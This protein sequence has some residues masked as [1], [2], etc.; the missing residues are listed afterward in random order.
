M[1]TLAELRGKIPELEGLDDNAAVDAIQQAYYPDIDRKQIA[2]RLGVQPVAAPKDQNQGDLGRGFKTAFEQLPQLGYGV[3]A[4]V[5][6]A[7][8]A[9]LGSGGVMSGIKEA[10]LKGYQDWGDK[11]NAGSKESDSWSYSYDQ[12]KAGNFGALVD[13]LQYGLGYSAGQGL[14]ALA[15]AGIGAVGGKVVL[16]T[17]AKEL[18]KGLVLK[19]AGVI[20]AT[21]AGKALGKD[22][23]ISMATQNVASKIGQSVGVGAMAFG[24]EGGEI[25]G[26]LTQQAQ[27]D[28]RDLTGAELGKAFA[29]TL[30]AGG[31]EFVGDKFGLDLVMGKSNVGSKLMGLAE[32]KAG[33]GGKVAR[34]ALAGAAAI[35]AEAGTEYLQTGL[36]EYGKGNEAN[37]LPMFQSEQN[38]AGALDAAMLGG[39]GG[40]SVGVAGGMMSRAR[41]KVEA[42]RRLDSAD[43]VPDMIGAATDLALA[44]IQAPVR[45]RAAGADTIAEIR[46]LDPE[47]QSEAIGL[48]GASKN[49]NAPGHV[50]RYAQNRL[51]ELLAPFRMVPV[52]EATE[53][54]VEQVNGDRMAYRSPAQILADGL[55]EIEAE[56]MARSTA[57]AQP[58]PTES[59]AAAGAPRPEGM[60]ERTGSRDGQLIDTSGQNAVAAY[61]NRM[62]QINTPA[63]RAFVQDVDAGRITPDDV[64]S[65]MLPKRATSA[66]QEANDRLAAAA[67]QAPTIQPGDLLTADGMPYGTRAAAAVRSTREGGGSVVQVPGGFV[68]R[69]EGAN[70]DQ[71]DVAAASAHAAGGGDGG[72]AVPGGSG[73]DVRRVPD[74]R[75]GVGVDAITA[76]PGGGGGSAVAVGGGSQPDAALSAEKTPEA[77]WNDKTLEQR[78]GALQAVGYT[79]A[80][81]IQQIANSRWHE[82]A[83]GVRAKVDALPADDAKSLADR[84]NAMKAA[85]VSATADQ[86]T[87]KGGPESAQ[88]E[89]AQNIDAAAHEAA[90]SPV[91]DLPQPTEAQKKAGNYAKGHAVINGLD[92]SIEN[93]AGSTRSGTDRGG[94]AWTNTLQHH[95]G[96]IKGTIGNDKDHVDAFVKPGTPQDYAGPVFVVDQIHPETGKFDEHKALIGFAS[97]AEA[98]SAYAANYAKDWKGLK[99]ITEM[100]FEQFKTWVKD[101]AKRMPASLKA[102]VDAKRS[103]SALAEAPASEG[104][105]AATSAT[106]RDWK[107]ATPAELEAEIHRLDGEWRDLNTRQRAEPER[108]GEQRAR[109][110]SQMDDVDRRRRELTNLLPDDQLDEADVEPEAKFGEPG[111]EPPQNWQTSLYQA[112]Q[113][114]R[115]MGIPREGVGGYAGK[116]LPAVLKLIAAK[117]PPTPKPKRP[118]KSFRKK[119]KVTTPVFVEETNSFEP[120]EIDADA[121]LSALDADV[122]ELERF[123]ACLK[124]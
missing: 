7:G 46:Q 76:A 83:A 21:E 13:W 80:A 106:E 105:T 40:A 32:S 112:R 82:L 5:G 50:R 29:A 113:Y 119:V 118:P 104:P 92:L 3:M 20:G 22:E 60:A 102:R 110:I 41:D 114:A 52:G 56:R 38:Q 115:D 84:I 75:V 88:P 12:A 23:L 107:T 93:P 27:K 8:E 16:G 61:V 123:L 63:A 45:P 19:E 51:D 30:A 58:P 90:T 87:Q 69:K 6:A 48:L 42:A 44:P 31:L 9:A 57:G 68:V 66:A 108:D 36:E 33:L 122:S 25:F 34:G 62:R 109:L 2:D 24:Q 14:Q 121:A 53:L 18:A 47:Q 26:D 65:L 97:E 85:K 59:E 72:S 37:P 73:G 74:G 11:I 111:Y 70:V 98:R 77:R 86:T 101:G 100:P 78:K 39:L 89:A 124:G 99:D 43:N 91:N 17:A 71:R 117:L 96:Y 116:E 49:Q 95:Y 4:G 28:G 15:S 81:Q 35:P 1:P 103:E 10:G 67:A 120:R 64:L 55:R 54:D 94:K 79:D